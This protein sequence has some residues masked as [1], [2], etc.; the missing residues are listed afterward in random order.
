MSCPFVWR[1][2]GLF[3][4]LNSDAVSTK[5]ASWK[6]NRRRSLNQSCIKAVVKRFNEFS[7]QDHNFTYADGLTR[8]S[9]PFLFFFLM[10][11]AEASSNMLCSSLSCMSCECPDKD[12]DDTEV[13]LECFSCV[14]RL[15]N[16]V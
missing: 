5:T 8:R 12:L 13:S 9:R 16:V 3:P 2:L 14:K 1:L 4:I 10:D 15:C 11:G 7:G 6:T